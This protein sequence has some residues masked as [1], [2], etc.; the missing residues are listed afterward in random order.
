MVIEEEI[1]PFQ[2]SRWHYDYPE[3]NEDILIQIACS[4]YENRKF[5]KRV[6]NIMNVMNISPPFRNLECK[7]R[8]PLPKIAKQMAKRVYQRSTMRQTLQLMEFEEESV[9]DKETSKGTV[10]Y[11]EIPVKRIAS[12]ALATRKLNSIRTAFVSDTEIRENRLPESKYMD[13]KPLQNYTPG[14]LKTNRIYV[15]NLCHNKV[16]EDM[17]RYLFSRYLYSDFPINKSLCEDVNLML[18][19]EI[20]KSG[21]LRGQAFVEYKVQDGFDINRAGLAIKELNAYMLGGKPMVLQYSL[22]A[23]NKVKESDVDLS[24]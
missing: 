4:L 10:G 6:L 23:F 21:R 9:S 11:H 24:P 16:T 8:V 17:L 12:T 22:S 15:K 5:Y 7:P 19:V 1:S 18:S 20:M 14:A 2:S 3:P 13:W